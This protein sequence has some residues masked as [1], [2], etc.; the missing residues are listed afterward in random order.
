MLLRLLA[1]VFVLNTFAPAAMASVDCD[2]M[3]GADMSDMSHDMTS[4]SMSDGEMECSMDQDDSCNTSQCLTSCAASFPLL[5]LDSTKAFAADIL[6]KH[7]K[8]NL[9]SLYEIYLPINTPPP[10]V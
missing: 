9:L 8:D 2:M 4:Q 3:S 6:G 7:P 10:L 1:L 5:S